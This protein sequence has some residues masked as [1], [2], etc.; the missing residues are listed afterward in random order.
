MCGVGGGLCN[1]VWCSMVWCGV[2]CDEWVGGCAGRCVGWLC[3]CSI[4]GCI[5]KVGVRERTKLCVT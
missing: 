5:E 4:K 3:E 2:T 1:V